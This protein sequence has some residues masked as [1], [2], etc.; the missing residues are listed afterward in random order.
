[1]TKAFEYKE[2]TLTPTD[3]AF[4]DQELQKL[5][6]FEGAIT[7]ERLKGYDFH[8]FL[9]PEYDLKGLLEKLGAAERKA[10][11]IYHITGQLITS[12]LKNKP[13]DGYYLPTNWG[14]MHVDNHQ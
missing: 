12:D 6:T 4:S 11:R 14:F 8:Y 10:K 3:L 13:V 1:M 2:L 5:L 9:M 7:S